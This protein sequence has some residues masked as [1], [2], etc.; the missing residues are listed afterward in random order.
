MEIDGH[1]CRALPFDKEILGQN[2]QKLNDRNVFV[3]KIPAEFK[4]KDLEEW[5][6]QYGPIKS[7]KISIDKDYK[8]NGYGFVLFENA[9]GAARAIAA[10]ANSDSL[11][12][13]KFQP[14]DKKDLQKMYNNLYVKNFPR[15]FNEQQ[16][17]Q[18]F[19]QYGDILSVVLGTN[20]HGSFAF[21][22]FGQE[23]AP[24]DYGY[25]CA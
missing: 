11:Q 1:P 5:F 8:S 7:A 17:R 9:E 3:K 24:R 2:K 23:G 4:S 22:C 13:N 18:V 20:E 19:Q 15:E 14:K 10:T 6:S 12:G 21:V 16:I 25:T